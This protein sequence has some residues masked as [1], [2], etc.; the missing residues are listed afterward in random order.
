MS[1]TV[2]FTRDD[3]YPPELLELPHWYALRT[4]ARFEKKTDGLLRA[5]GIESFAAVAEVERRWADRTRKVGMPIFSGYI[6]VRIPLIRIAD[7]LRW[8]G[9]VGLVK[10]RGVP[11]PLRDDEIAG[12]IHLA[13][14]IT[15]S[16][17]L[18]NEA[19]DQLTPG[20]RV[21]VVEGPFRGMEGTLVEQG[22]G[23]YVAVRIEAIRQAKAVQVDPSLLE[24]VRVEA[25]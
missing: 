23:S 13:R 6:F 14:G 7:A 11:S 16:G 1:S 3:H 18:P 9:A 2:F 20:E 8:P 22:N 4:R 12:V 19:E 15:E 25:A 5:A 24:R 21:R 17:T 10:R